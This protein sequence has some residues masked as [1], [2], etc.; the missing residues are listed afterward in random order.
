MGHGC[1]NYDWFEVKGLGGIGW[2]WG[3]DRSFGRPRWP[4]F[5]CGID[6]PNHMG[7]AS[8]NL[9]LTHIASLASEKPFRHPL[10]FCI[11]LA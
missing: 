1:T 10:K 5:N 3:L 8:R 11:H 7:V 6:S 9:A 4:M 2:G